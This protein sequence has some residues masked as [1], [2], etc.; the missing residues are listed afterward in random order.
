MVTCRRRNVMFLSR[1]FLFWN[2][3]QNL[4]LLKDEIR[5]KII[6]RLTFQNQMLKQNSKAWPIEIQRVTP[7]TAWRN[8]SEET[9]HKSNPRPQWMCKANP[10]KSPPPWV[11]CVFKYHKNPPHSPTL[12]PWGGGGRNFNWEGHYGT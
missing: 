2:V 4:L 6:R 7:V 9:R 12:A 5:G 3:S 11:N 8:Y 10:E 1:H